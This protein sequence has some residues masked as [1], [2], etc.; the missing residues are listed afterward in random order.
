MVPCVAVE[1]SVKSTKEHCVGARRV[2]GHH[3]PTAFGSRARNPRCAVPFPD[4]CKCV[5][6]VCVLP[7]PA[8]DYDATAACV[9][10]H[11]TKASGRGAAHGTLNP[12]V[13]V[14]F[15][16]ITAGRT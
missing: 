9:K 6:V 14:Q 4:V 3:V 2:V 16:C 7:N 15:P 10:G 12:R 8:E 13:A 5:G 1:P 11:A